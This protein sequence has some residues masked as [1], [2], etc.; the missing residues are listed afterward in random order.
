MRRLFLVILAIIICLPLYAQTD[1]FSVEILVPQED[2]PAEAKAQLLAKLKQI[3]VNYGMIDDGIGSRFVLTA[4][5]ISSVRDIVPS[6]PPR[7]SQKLDVILYVGDIVEDKVYTSLSL[8]VTGVGQN[9]NKAYINAFQR[10][11]VRSEALSEWMKSTKEKVY[12]YYQMNG[13]GIVARAERLA[14]LGDYDTALSELL[15]IPEFCPASSEGW[16]LAVELTQKK[17]DKEGAEL[18][19]EAKARWARGQDESAAQDAI[20]ILS[21]IDLSSSSADAA[22]ELV[23]SITRHLN[24]RQVRREEERQ[25]AWDFQVKQH[26]DDLALRRQQLKDQTA[27]E[28]A[29]AEAVKTTSNK[30]AG[31]DINKV[32]NVLKGWFGK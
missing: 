26:E 23:K 28:K 13:A 5:V 1:G 10:I 6:T 30:V 29:K 9:D 25:R 8:P 14:E 24:S 15:S 19:R 11:P 12:Y 3:A 18:L 16:A 32:A 21:S 27:I 2:M 7:I 17:R 20:E 4:D 22:E 31:I